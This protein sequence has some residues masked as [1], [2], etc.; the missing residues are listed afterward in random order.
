MLYYCIK[1][2]INGRIYYNLYED[3]YLMTS[4]EIKGIFLIRLAVGLDRTSLTEAEFS[5]Y[6]RHA[7]K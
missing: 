1:Y 5:H 7:E 6:K 4:F 3:F 2:I